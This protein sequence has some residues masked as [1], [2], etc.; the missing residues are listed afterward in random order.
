MHSLKIRITYLTVPHDFSNT[1]VYSG[2]SAKY[3]I[4]G[5]MNDWRSWKGD[6]SEAVEELVKAL[7]FVKREDIVYKIAN[8]LREGGF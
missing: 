8:K 4:N 3:A 2:Q 1:I 6:T 7:N 5:Y